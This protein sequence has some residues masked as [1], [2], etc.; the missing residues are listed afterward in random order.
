[1][2]KDNKR[3]LQVSKDIR[4]A[5][6]VKRYHCWPVREQTVA[7][8]SW[9]ICRILLS[10][11]TEEIAQ[12]LLPHAVLHDVGEVSVGDLP[13]PIKKMNPDLERIFSGIE[14]SAVHDL[15]ETWKLPPVIIHEWDGK[16]R[17][18]FKAAEYIEMMEFGMEEVVRGNE[19]GRLIFNR[20]CVVLHE[21][22]HGF[23]PEEEWE[24]TT[25]SKIEQYLETR[26]NMWGSYV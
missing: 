15:M 25:I 26:F 3:G 22:V 5:G 20:C 11:T 1:M 2:S 13:Y 12:I 9:Q 23:T 18:V 8:H 6:T 24:E 10:I 16:L 4:M 7:E 21:M 14:A 17:W 19:F